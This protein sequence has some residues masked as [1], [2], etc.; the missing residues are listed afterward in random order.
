MM[1]HKTNIPNQNNR[2]ADLAHCYARVFVGTDDGQRI[3][4]DL[5]ARF[6]A[7]AP[8]FPPGSTLTDAAVTEG[9]ALVTRQIKRL[10]EQ[11]LK[12]TL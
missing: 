9:K 2:Q 12:K 1:A 11:G 10:V 7:D 3:L 5:E 6:P 8:R 4:A